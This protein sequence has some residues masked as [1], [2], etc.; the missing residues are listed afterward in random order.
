VLINLVLTSLPMFL[1]SFFEI[2]K[3]VRKILDFYRSSFFW[4][5]DQKKNKYHLTKW[6]IVYRPKEQGG[7]GIVFLEIKSRSYLA[8]GFLSY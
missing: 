7:L 3:G 6:N 5:S 4:Q 2:P 1:L 8:N